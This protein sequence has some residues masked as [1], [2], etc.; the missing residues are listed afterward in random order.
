MYAILKN[1]LF[2]LDAERAHHLTTTLLRL[3][4][5][6]GL[7]R[8]IKW[9]MVG[10]VYHQPTTVSGLQFRNI[11]GL[12]AGFDKN[13]E[14]L[15]EMD[16]LGFGAVEIGTVT[17]KGQEGNPKPRL[18]RLPADTALINRMGFNNQGVD[19]AGYLI[20][21]FRRKK[22]R[23]K[24]IVGGNIG[25]NKITPNEQAHEDYRICF[26]KL[27]GLVDYFVVNVSSPNTPNLRELQDKDALRV[28]FKTLRS[29]EPELI[30][31]YEKTR[32][33]FV[34]ISPDNSFDQIDDIL[35]LVE[36]YKLAGIVATN[37]TISRSDLNTSADIVEAMGAGGL[38]GKPVQSRSDEVVAYIRSKNKEITIIG[39]GGIQTGEDAMQKIEA[40]ADLVQVYSC[41]IYEGPKMISRITR[42][43]AESI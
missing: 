7:L 21:E 33:L 37:T 27:Y 31:R 39:V 20:E 38:S 8:L 42:R 19:A 26:E 12:A 2:R 9:T 32:P 6:F 40:G 43:L 36:E 14:Y 3:G 30:S 5:K 25:K 22:P 35:V 11:L 29:V 15:A 16:S 24:L 28:I 41:F 18:F 4:R 10:K 1:L 17:P 34:K 13:A 23:S